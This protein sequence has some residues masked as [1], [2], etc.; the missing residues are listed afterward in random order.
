MFTLTFNG[1]FELKDPQEFLER[2]QEL[3]NKHD[4]AYYGQ[5]STTN[6][7]EYVDFQKI[8]EPVEE[9]KNE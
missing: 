3:L 8:E 2:L 7:G 1:R 4:V 6:L 9:K 5:I